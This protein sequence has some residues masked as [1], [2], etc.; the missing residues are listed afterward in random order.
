VIA[1]REM[2]GWSVLR[3]E[4]KALAVVEKIESRKEQKEGRKQRGKR[5]NETTRHEACMTKKNG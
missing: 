5:D 4:K 2:D 1:W 3:E